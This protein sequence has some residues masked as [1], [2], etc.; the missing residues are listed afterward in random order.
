MTI[1]AWV[2]FILWVFA[3]VLTDYEKKIVIFV[4]IR[5]IF[6]HL[7]MKICQSPDFFLQLLS[8]FLELL[9]FEFFRLEFF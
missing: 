7:V 9:S 8:F 6:G 3:W 2:F 5:K 4:S 1:F